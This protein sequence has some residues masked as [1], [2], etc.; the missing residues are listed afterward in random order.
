[1]SVTFGGERE[2]IRRGRGDLWLRLSAFGGSLTLQ[3][4]VLGA[5]YA[6]RCRDHPRRVLLS[7]EGIRKAANAAQKA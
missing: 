6:P 1:M 5:E 4:G 7:L 3:N 2:W